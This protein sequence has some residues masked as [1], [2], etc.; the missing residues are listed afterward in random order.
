MLFLAGG[1]GGWSARWTKIVEPLPD[2]PYQ[3][4]T[5]YIKYDDNETPFR[6]QWA[7]D[8]GKLTFLDSGAFSALTKNVVIDLDEYIEFCR[9]RRKYFD[10]VAA[11]DVIHDPDA[12]LKNWRLMQ[13][14]GFPDAVPCF[15]IGEPWDYLRE[16]KDADMIGLGVAAMQRRGD[17]VERWIGQCFRK[18]QDWGSTARVHGYAITSFDW[19]WRF[20]WYSV[21]SSSWFMGARYGQMA[22]LEGRRIV[23]YHRMKPP[24]D[25][26]TM[27]LW[28]RV[29]PPARGSMEEYFPLLRHNITTYARACELI[30]ESRRRVAS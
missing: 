18:L 27:K 11:L 7:H 14:A 10:H 6:M 3:I 2:M 12:S 23:M 13:E 15:H 16:M 1:E 30:N 20:P 8:Q 24:K 9:T 28:R 5:S 26:K 4:M 17:P 19:M 29:M 25:L 21:D 22:V